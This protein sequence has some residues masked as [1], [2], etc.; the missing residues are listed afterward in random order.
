MYE[1]LGNTPLRVSAAEVF[2]QVRGKRL[3]PIPRRMRGNQEREIKIS[4]RGHLREFTRNMGHKKPLGR[5]S[6]PPRYPPCRRKNIPPR[7]NSYRRPRS[8]YR[9]RTEKETAERS[10]N[11]PAAGHNHTIA[12]GIQ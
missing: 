8:P 10:E 11:S 6:S 1:P 7:H 3:V 5:G 4:T 9:P 12:G 2:A